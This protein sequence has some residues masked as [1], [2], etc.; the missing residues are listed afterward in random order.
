MDEIEN[1]PWF[2]N[3]TIPEFLPQESTNEPLDAAFLE[4]YGYKQE[5]THNSQGSILKDP[6]SSHF[7]QKVIDRIPALEIEEDNEIDSDDSDSKSPP[8]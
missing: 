1:H 7:H 6:E 8:K 4:Q 2:T 3:S 5:K